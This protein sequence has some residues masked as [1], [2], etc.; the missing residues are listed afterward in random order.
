MKRS[1]E[2][3]GTVVKLDVKLQLLSKLIVAL[4]PPY[5]LTDFVSTGELALEEEQ[6]EAAGARAADEAAAPE[7]PFDP[8]KQQA[9]DRNQCVALQ[10]LD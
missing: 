2:M 4:Q 9:A 3:T 7:E 1:L 10:T 5:L 8:A 6:A